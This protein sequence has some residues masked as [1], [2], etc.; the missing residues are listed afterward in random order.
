MLGA[1]GRTSVEQERRWYM[2]WRQVLSPE[3]EQGTIQ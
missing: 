3:Q 2:K 1:E